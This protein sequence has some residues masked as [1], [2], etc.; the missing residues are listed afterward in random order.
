VRLAP[1]VLLAFAAIGATEAAAQSSAPDSFAEFQARRQ[2]VLDRLPRALLFV[3][4]R[5]TAKADDQHGFIQEPDFYYLTGLADAIGAVLLLDGPRRESWLFVPR[6]PGFER[7][8]VALGAPSEAR[9][10]LQHVAQLEDL[11]TL[12]DRR[13]AEDP[14]LEIRLAASEGRGEPPSSVGPPA[15][16]FFAW[17]ERLLA[18]WPAALISP[19]AGLIAELRNIKSAGEILALRRAARSSA[20]ALLAGLKALEPGRSQRQIEAAVVTGC[21]QAG[22]N[23]PSFWPWTM[24]GPNALFPDVFEAFAD[25]GHLDRRIENGDLVRMDVGCDADHYAGDV[26]RTAPASGRF[27][28]G[29]RETWNLLVAAYET[30]LDS[31][32]DG[33]PGADVIAASLGEVERRRATLATPLARQAARVLLQDGG[34]S[35]WQI[36]GVGLESGEGFSIPDTLRAGMVVAF[37]PIFAVEGQGFYLED[38]ILVTPEGHEVLTQGLPYEADEIERAMGR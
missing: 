26:G 33:L 5:S 14:R 7:A 21:V 37:E 28:P 4:S 24:S 27:D 29:Q 18:R 32:R 30:G 20:A 2:R 25:C 1:V 16:P 6:E 8:R 13:L 19:G 31:M 35:W 3:P 10:G 9:L 12:V 38:M 15:A 34:T 17:R 36:H 23:G 11:A 22:A